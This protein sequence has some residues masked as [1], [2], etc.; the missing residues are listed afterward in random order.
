MTTD[1]AD[2]PDDRALWSQAAADNGSAFTVLFDRHAKAVYNH[3]FRLT[4]SWA[5][6][7]DHV[8]NTFLVA[9]RKRAGMRLE[10]DSALPWLLM[11]ATNVVRNDRRGLARRLRLTRRVATDAPVPDHADDVAARVDDQRRMATVL[12]A[13]NRLPRNEREAIALCVWSGVSY[14]DAAAVLG[15]TEGSVRARVSKAKSRLSTLLNAP[16]DE[17]RQTVTVAPNAPQEDR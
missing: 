14:S 9:W 3:C 10:R 17:Q 11:V 4:A 12:E 7:E 5:A 1:W 2:G 13:L 8:Q 16:P 6:A 15:I